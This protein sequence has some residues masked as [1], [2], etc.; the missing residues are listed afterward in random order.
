MN[1]RFKNFNDFVP[2]SAAI[3]RTLLKD[4]SSSDLKPRMLAAANSIHASEFESKAQAGRTL[5]SIRAAIT[6]EGNSLPLAQFDPQEPLSIRPST[7][8]LLACHHDPPCSPDSQTASS[9]APLDASSKK[10]PNRRLGNFP[11]LKSNWLKYRADLKEILS[12]V[13]VWVRY[14]VY[15]IRMLSLRPTTPKELKKFWK[16][17]DQIASVLPRNLELGNGDILNVKNLAA[18]LDRKLTPPVNPYKPGKKVALEESDYENYLGI[19]K[20]RHIFSARLNYLEQNLESIKISTGLNPVE[21]QVKDEVADFIHGIDPRSHHRKYDGELHTVIHSIKPQLDEWRLQSKRYFLV[22]APEDYFPTIFPEAGVKYKPKINLDRFAQARTVQE[23]RLPAPE[24][25]S[26]HSILTVEKVMQDSPANINLEEELHRYAMVEGF[27]NILED[28]NFAAHDLLMNELKPRVPFYL[29][30]PSDS[31]IPG[32]TSIFA[33]P[34]K[35][36]AAWLQERYQQFYDTLATPSMVY[37]QLKGLPEDEIRIRSTLDTHADFL[38]FLSR[39][40]QEGLEKSSSDIK[41]FEGQ[42]REIESRY[43]T[44]GHREKEALDD[45]RQAAIKPD[46]VVER[47]FVYK[48]YQQGIIDKSTRQKL[49]PPGGLTRDVFMKNLGTEQI[50]V[51]GLMSNFEQDLL[52]G[53]VTSEEILART[54][55]ILAQSHIDKLDST[56]KQIYITPGLFTTPPSYK[57]NEALKIFQPDNVKKLARSEQDIIMLTKAYI[58]G[59]LPPKFS[60]AGYESD[61][62][63][64]LSQIKIPQS[65]RSSID[66]IGMMP[67]FPNFDARLSA[68]YLKP[69]SEGDARLRGTPYSRLT[70]QSMRDLNELSST[71]YSTRDVSKEER[72]WTSRIDVFEKEHYDHIGEIRKIMTSCL[73]ETDV[74]HSSSSH[75]IP[76]PQRAIELILSLGKK[77]KTCASIKTRK[78]K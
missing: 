62:D 43:K 76:A 41:Q 45:F 25:E 61:L 75:N 55:R 17:R 47:P 66:Q 71:F 51:K 13:F 40:D 3:V 52:K 72:T 33:S 49:N 1:L 9:T 4:F 11:R 56:A 21:K 28:I 54:T 10:T 38:D 2:V 77:I 65:G 58:E 57:F 6:S 7:D 31:L 37:Q 48:L 73:R 46:L 68:F 78:K 15:K 60:D 20:T 69:L 53:L 42:L 74:H 35:E 30:E 14:Q 26:G 70:Q 23:N 44:H 18:R 12:D 32:I 36:N 19:L 39:E 16:V 8:H 24:E 34:S 5:S 63:K 50:F 67:R 27:E 29:A 22:E 59:I 64:F